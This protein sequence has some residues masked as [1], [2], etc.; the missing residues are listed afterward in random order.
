MADRG[1]VRPEKGYQWISNSR[2]NYQ[3]EYLPSG[4]PH[5]A[6]AHCVWTGDGRWRPAD[7]YQVLPNH[8][9]GPVDNG[10]PHERLPMVVWAKDGKCIEP[11]FRFLWKSRHPYTE[12]DL[13]VIPEPDKTIHRLTPPLNGY[14]PFESN[15]HVESDGDHLKAGNGYRWAASDPAR[16]DNYAVKPIS[17]LEKAKGILF[18]ISAF[19]ELRAAAYYGNR[20][21]IH[22][23]DV[24]FSPANPLAPTKRDLER[25]GDI[26]KHE[27]NEVFDTVT[28]YLESFDSVRFYPPHLVP[29][30]VIP[31]SVARM[32]DAKLNSYL[33]E[34][35]AAKA[36]WERTRDQLGNL[37]PFKPEDHDRILELQYQT[38]KADNIIATTNDDIRDR[39]RDLANSPE[40]KPFVL[41]DD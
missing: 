10:T 9:I 35:E 15:P 5:P 11:Q 24:S 18:G 40:E 8:N 41:V 7:G 12:N 3:V 23:A 31:K 29:D 1:F 30:A 38:N 25:P 17:L 6:C 13:E 19:R 22:A 33:S 16:A 14:F 26:A 36:E 27:S 28:D 39:V 4:V 37:S 34:R 20:A 32:D 2:D 21:A